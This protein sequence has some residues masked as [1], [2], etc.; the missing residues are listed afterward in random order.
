MNIKRTLNKMSLQG[1]NILLSFVINANIHV[2]ILDSSQ[3]SLVLPSGEQSFVK[4]KRN[5]LIIKIAETYDC[6]ILAHVFV[7]LR[8]FL[9]NVEKNHDC[10]IFVGVFVFIYYTLHLCNQFCCKVATNHNLIMLPFPSFSYLD[11]IH[12]LLGNFFFDQSLLLYWFWF[13]E[14]IGKVLNTQIL[15]NPSQIVIL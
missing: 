1:E 11:F 5:L 4:L 3:V 6:H 12:A 2:I 13:Y 15:E 10:L 8:S 9:L 7:H 14:P